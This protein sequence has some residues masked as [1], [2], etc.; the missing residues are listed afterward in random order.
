M[1]KTR[2]LCGLFLTALVSAC[3]TSP[4]STVKSFYSDVE[5]GEL[6][7]AKTLISV[8]VISMLGDQ[9]LTAALSA[10]TQN[11]SRCGGIRSVSPTL[12]THGEISVGSTS[13]DY[14]GSCARRTENTKLIKEDGHWK[15]TGS[16]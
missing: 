9:K 8:Q 13:V 2:V 14:N 15:I 10:E 3:G 4:E 11:I 5:K 6:T 16:K 7:E 12:Q 1:R